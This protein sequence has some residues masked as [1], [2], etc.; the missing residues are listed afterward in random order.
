MKKTKLKFFAFLIS[1]VLLLLLKPWI[2]I[3]SAVL[4]GLW[5]FKNFINPLSDV[6]NKIKNFFDLRKLPVDEITSQKPER[7]I[8]KLINECEKS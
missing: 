5:C 3:L 4:F 2:G 7:G 6:E 8:D 1:T